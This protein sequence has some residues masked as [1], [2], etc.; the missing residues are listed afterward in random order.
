GSNNAYPTLNGRLDTLDA[1]AEL[2]NCELIAKGRVGSMPRG[3]QYQ[4]GGSW[5]AHMQ[6]DPALTRSGLLAL[7][8]AGH[9]LTLTGVPPGTGLRMGIDRDRDG[10]LDRDEVPAGSDPGDPLSIPGL[11]VTPGGGV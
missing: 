11:T 9:E 10:Y 6:N 7:A 5:K 2:G 4:S 1:Q 3:W 8:S